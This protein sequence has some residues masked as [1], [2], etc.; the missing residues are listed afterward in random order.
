MIISAIIIGI[1]KFFTR[2]TRGITFEVVLK[3]DK[4]PITKHQDSMLIGIK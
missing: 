1:R 2:V 4:I 3:L